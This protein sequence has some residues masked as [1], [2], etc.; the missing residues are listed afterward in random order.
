MVGEDVTFTTVL[1][2]E[3][4]QIRADPSQLQQ[5]IISLATNAREAMASGGKLTL[6]TANVDLDESYLDGRLP[7]LAG[8]HVMLA[9]GDTGHGIDPAI[10]ARIFE[11][12]F[13]TKDEK[14]VGKG[15]GLGLAAVY[16]MVQQCGG[17]IAVYSEVGF[18]S[19]FKIYFPRIDWPIA[20]F[21]LG[22]EAESLP[23]G[24]ETILVIEDEEQLR[25]M[26]RVL[27]EDRGYTVFEAS[28]GD[29]AIKIVDALT[30]PLDLVLTDV[31][32]PGLSGPQ[33][34]EQLVTRNPDLQVVFMSGFTDDMVVRHGV[35]ASGDHFVQKPFTSA[36]LVRKIR[37]V[38]DARDL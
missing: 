30:S 32:M 1:D 27:L 29:D 18:G 15:A 8:A 11:P 38:L 4:G 16:G 19:T 9:V 26:A 23:G 17:A 3:L 31:V 22:I 33:I 5:I 7:A 10:R 14:L 12:F 24:S 25:V 20:P 2:P 36:T 6:Q 28:G 35:L 37:H 13:T 21:T 34:A